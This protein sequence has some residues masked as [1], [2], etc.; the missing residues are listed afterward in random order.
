V[1]A[2]ELAEEIGA[3]AWVLRARNDL[4]SL[5]Q[6]RVIGYSTADESLSMPH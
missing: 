3:Q 1:A 6:D 4:A 2:I 5:K